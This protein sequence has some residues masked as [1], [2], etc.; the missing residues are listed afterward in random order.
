MKL[1]F[2]SWAKKANIGENYKIDIRFDPMGKS[3]IEA[4]KRFSYIKGLWG[5]NDEEWKGICYHHVIKT[6]N[7]K[8]KG[9]VT[10]AL[11]HC[12]EIEISEEEIIN[13][14]C[15]NE[16]DFLNCKINNV[17]RI[18]T[19]IDSMRSEIHDDLLSTEEYL[20]YHE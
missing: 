20:I 1:Y 7:P 4:S 9:E 3:E 13:R 16:N 17:F 14:L 2:C 19:I 5:Y 15:E 6:I 8:N 10:Y 11:I 12:Y 18:W